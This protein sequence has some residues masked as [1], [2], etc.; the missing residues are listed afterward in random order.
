MSNF[1]P[2]ELQTFDF[3][4]KSMSLFLK[5]SYGISD[6]CKM[7]FDILM[8]LINTGDTFLLKYL[9][10]YSLDLQGNPNYFENTGIDPNWTPNS[11]TPDGGYWLDL[12]ASIFGLSRTVRCAIRKNGTTWE[13]VTPAYFITLSNYELMLYLQ[14]T[15]AKNS[16][17]GSLI[18]LREI[19]T[20]ST[21]FNINAYY[22]NLNY[23][24]QWVNFHLRRTYLTDLGIFY[25]RPSDYTK[26]QPLACKIYLPKTNI[27]VTEN[28]QVLFKNHYLT[29]ESLGIAYNLLIADTV[30]ASARFGDAYFYGPRYAYDQMY[31]FSNS[32]E[33]PPET[34]VLEAER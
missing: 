23:D 25:I 28:I 11:G 19:Y 24:P 18:S 10:I 1:L 2:E 20:G 29:I 21:I 30:Y 13:E 3:Y 8:N 31:R 15:I 32:E 16:F 17:D 4:L 27:N 9:N 34:N 12:L 5:E 22:N 7:Y 33:V 26:D 14:A 6:R